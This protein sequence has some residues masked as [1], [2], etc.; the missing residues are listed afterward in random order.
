MSAAPNPP[1][2]VN[3]ASAM[4]RLRPNLS[5]ASRAMQGDPQ[6][7]PKESSMRVARD[8]VQGFFRQLHDC[9]TCDGPMLGSAG[10]PPACGPEARVPMGPLA[11]GRAILIQGLGNT[12]VPQA[13]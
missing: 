12:T 6:S 1:F 8:A 4:K 9:S 5:Y 7:L 3:L 2:D 11:A 10:V 13:V